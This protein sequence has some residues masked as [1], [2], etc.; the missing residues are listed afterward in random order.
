MADGSA[1]NV[2]DVIVSKVEDGHLLLIVT[3]GRSQWRQEA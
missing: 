3:G 2:D 1:R